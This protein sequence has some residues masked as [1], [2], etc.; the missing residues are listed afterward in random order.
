MPRLPGPFGPPDHDPD[1]KRNLDLHPEAIE[2]QPDEST[3]TR[4][5]TE[6]TPEQLLG[7]P[8]AQRDDS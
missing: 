1:E 8:D 3:D 7:D 4:N 6:V 5:D 2:E